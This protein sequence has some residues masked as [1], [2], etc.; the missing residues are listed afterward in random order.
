MRIHFELHNLLCFE[1]PQYRR[2]TAVCRFTGQ[3]TYSG[4]SHVCERVFIRG[5]VGGI[6]SL[7]LVSTLRPPASAPEALATKNSEITDLGLP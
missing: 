7:T 1:G 2:R 6:I 4:W 5:I 3:S